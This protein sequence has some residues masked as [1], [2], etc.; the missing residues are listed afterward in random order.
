[1][2]KLL[3]TE[4]FLLYFFPFLSFN[5][6]QLIF[7]ENPRGYQVDSLNSLLFYKVDAHYQDCKH[8]IQNEFGTLDEDENKPDF[9]YIYPCFSK[10]KYRI[11]YY[12]PILDIKF[13]LTEI[14]YFFLVA[15]TIT[16]YLRRFPF[17]AETA[18]IEAV[19]RLLEA[20]LETKFHSCMV[21][22]VQNSNNNFFQEEHLYHIFLGASRF[23][24]SK[25]FR[26]QINQNLE[27]K[28]ILFKT[29]VFLLER[30][31]AEEG[32]P[33]VAV[34]ANKLCH[35]VTHEKT[36]KPNT[37]SYLSSFFKELAR[38]NKIK[39]SNKA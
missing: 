17:L 8:D 25:K 31:V 35:S 30:Y 10:E 6:T 29:I 14:N 26:L 32:K 15:Q 3:L 39:N 38:Q 1:M 2:Q 4:N 21:S 23:F 24:Q 36:L 37:P 33:K 20:C 22:S 27:S 34:L 18:R 5:L 16:Y 13:D 19:S 11:F 7:L 28:K 12:E 9:C